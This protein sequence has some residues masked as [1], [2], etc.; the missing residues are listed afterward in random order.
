MYLLYNN[1]YFVGKTYKKYLRRSFKE[2]FEGI[3][4]K[5]IL[6][7]YTDEKVKGRC[8]FAL[9]KTHLEYA[10]SIW[11]PAHKESIPQINKIQRKAARVV[12]NCYERTE[13]VTRL[14]DG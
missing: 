2:A 5:R 8:Y 1:G 12:K 9:V 3:Y 7:M 11:D 6:G 4:I 14:L 10:A 13:S